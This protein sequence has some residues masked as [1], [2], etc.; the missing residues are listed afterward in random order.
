MHFFCFT[1]WFFDIEHSFCVENGKLV[2]YTFTKKETLQIRYW[3]SLLNLS[4][5]SVIVYARF[6]T[7][8]ALGL[9]WLDSG[10]CVEE[11][12]EL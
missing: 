5:L 11:T 9:L 7:P 10:G 4:L 6:I 12:E 8:E 2:Y 1:L 3:G